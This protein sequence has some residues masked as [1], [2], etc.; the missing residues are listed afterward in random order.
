MLK[1]QQQQNNCAQLEGRRGR[2]QMVVGFTTIYAIGVYHHWCCEL[3][4]RS[5]R[6]VQ[7]YMINLSVTCDRL[8]VFSGSSTNKTDRHDITE[9]LLK[10]TL[11]T[12]KPNQSNPE[13]GPFISNDWHKVN[14]SQRLICISIYLILSLMVCV[15]ACVLLYICNLFHPRKTTCWCL[16]VP[17]CLVRHEIFIV[18]CHR[19][20]DYQYQTCL[21]TKAYYSSCRSI[22]L[23]SN[24]TM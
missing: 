20:D 7:H 9:I 6:G 15:I 5:D 8:V 2:D 1:S 17:D 18:S 16:P 12:I 3:E 22:C 4:S 23:H 21:V 14:T 24:D 11:N 13:S 10:M 19:Y